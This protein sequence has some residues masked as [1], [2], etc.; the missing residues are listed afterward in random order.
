MANTTGEQRQDIIEEA[1]LASQ[2][3]KPC[4]CW[5]KKCS[6]GCGLS[7]EAIDLWNDVKKTLLWFQKKI[8]NIDHKE[9][10]DD[11]IRR[12]ER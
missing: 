1:I 11:L 10:I 7:I 6:R 8:T 5:E 9:I 3:G 4:G 12:L 2:D